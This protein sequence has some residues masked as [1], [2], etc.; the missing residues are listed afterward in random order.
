MTAE[1]APAF[2]FYAAD[3]LS[4]EEQELMSCAQAGAYVRLLARQWIEGSV[5]ADLPALAKLAGAKSL[6]EMEKLWPAI[7]PKFKPNGTA[8]RLVNARLEREREKQRAWREGLADN[9]RRG[10]TARW[11]KDGPAN[12]PAIAKQKQGQCARN[13]SSLSTLQSSEVRTPLPPKGGESFARFWTAYPRKV[14]KGAALK[15][16]QRIKPDEALAARILASVE[17]HAATSEWQQDGGQFIPHPRTFL[18]QGRWD[19]EFPGIAPAN[20][21]P[22][23][24]WPAI[25]GLLDAKARATVR[26]M[27]LDVA[28]G[29]L[30]MRCKPDLRDMV[31]RHYEASLMSARDSAAPGMRLRFEVGQ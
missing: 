18:A 24:P 13:A 1:Q 22:P 31:K 25:L 5:P 4:D 7:A 28:D 16:W 12:G 29:A 14:G 21:G 10:A 19:D 8:G 23:D 27:T 3:F 17:E 15:A 2:Q 26:M 9:G 20:G 6:R 11:G 30:V